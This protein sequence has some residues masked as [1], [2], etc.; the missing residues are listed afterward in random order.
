MECIFKNPFFN[1]DN[2]FLINENYK[3]IN[4]LS[5]KEIYSYFSKMYILCL[6]NNH[7]LDDRI[8][9][10]CLSLKDLEYFKENFLI[11]KCNL[12][13][14]KNS[15]HKNQ[16]V[17][18][19]NYY[20]N[21]IKN[22]NYDEMNL[23]LPLINL[24]D[25]NYKKYIKQYINDS[26]FGDYL[27][28][29]NI[30][31]FYNN[32][33]CN[34]NYLRN[35][36]MNMDSTDYW[37]NMSK[38]NLTNKFIDREFK[39]S[40]NEKIKDVKIKNL[41]N[42]LNEFP[43][44][45]DLY[46]NYLYRND[47]HVD[48]SLVL[49]NN[50]YN[51]Y[52]IDNNLEYTID[53]LNNTLDDL[54]DEHE[55]YILLVSLLISKKYCH[56][57]LKNINILNKYNYIINKYKL[58]IRYAMCYAWLCMYSEECIKKSFIC[59]DDRFVFTIDEAHNLP[60]F[61]FKLDELRS[62]PYYSFLVSEEVANLKNNIMGVRVEN[63]N[64]GVCDL[65]E[66]RRRC[67]I[68]ITEDESKN[69]LDGVSM[70]NLGITGSIIP[71]CVTLFNPLQTKFSSFARYYN[72]YYCNSDIDVICNIECNNKFIERVYKFFNDLELNYKKLYDD[73]LSIYSFKN[74][75]IIVNEEYI[76]EKIVNSNYDYE[77]VLEN[78]DNPEVKLLFYKKYLDEK[79]L[80][81]EKYFNSKKWMDEKYNILF[82]IELLEDIKIVL[83]SEDD[84]NEKYNSSKSIFMFKESIKF[85]IFGVKLNHNFEIFNT[86]Y[87]ASFFSIISKFHL[88]C[89][90]GYYDGD[91]V[92]LL[93]SCV[94]AAN[95]LINL[96]YK[97]FAGSI[98][99][100]EI[101]NKYR[102]RGYS[103]ILNDS[104]KIKFI[105]YV[106]SLDKTSM[107]YNNP[108]LRK[109]KEIDSILGYFEINDKFFNPREVL[110]K[111]YLNNKPVDLN[112]NSVSLNFQW[113]EEN[114]QIISNKTESTNLLKIMDLNF[115]NENGYIKPVKKWYFDAIY[116]NIN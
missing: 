34:I 114:N 40:L 86:K 84:K 16:V 102:T 69:I 50:G 58:G 12:K 97:Y 22:D 108:S 36:L 70:S 78:L 91:N 7:E 106:L 63:I 17:L 64:L 41:L 46:L 68:F 39:L 57:I 26:N 99:P 85:K 30:N 24:T 93:P 28:I 71:A 112:Y 33:N 98:D 104:E 67:N 54:E 74:T 13:L 18:V 103:T 25:T 79:I 116:D 65:D 77:Y 95:T 27:S 5:L 51:L 94:S 107:M 105:K 115:I 9:N 66:F 20:L 59:E 48:I 87:P 76:N 29:K 38:L 2:K 32:K 44:E 14:L 100:I 3:Y 11:F 6:K 23:L 1:N 19:D 49:K 8:Y 56:L 43:K 73:N 80:D 21:L 53:F 72:E 90:R 92:Y 82:K 55:I 101:I 35:L 15:V 83:K 113:R 110:Y 4:E 10:D 89:V 42:N 37:L 96:D 61:T 47:V 62:N 111:Y 75:I 31:N 52:Y 109:Q 60:N 45:G 88:P 81:N